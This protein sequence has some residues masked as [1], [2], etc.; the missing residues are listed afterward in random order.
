MR[1]STEQSKNSI[2]A[3]IFSKGTLKLPIIVRTDL[4]IHDGDKVLFLKQ[5]NKWV[6]TTHKHNI[7]EAQEYFAK[8]KQQSNVEYSVDDFIAE[9]RAEAVRELAE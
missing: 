7:Q 4:D 9:R 6:V 2:E 5:N 8:L 1:I 3:K